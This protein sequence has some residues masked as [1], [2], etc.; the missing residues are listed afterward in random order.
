MLVDVE[1]EAI[2]AVDYDPSRRR[3]L[4]VF[5]S[6]QRY[7]YRNVPR[8]VHRAFLDAESKGRFFQGEIRGR[9]AYEKLG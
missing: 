7:A 6:G 2:R 4:V 8:R 3:L 9:F 5:T 1:S